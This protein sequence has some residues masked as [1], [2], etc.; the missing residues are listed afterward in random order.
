MWRLHFCPL[1]VNMRQ[2]AS[3]LCFSFFS[4]LVP[5][6]SVSDIVATQIVTKVRERCTDGAPKEVQE[7]IDGY[8][9]G[10]R[11]RGCFIVLVG[12]KLRGRDHSLVWGEGWS[13][14]VTLERW[15]EEVVVGW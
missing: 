7:R 5:T 14:R 6:V 12:S 3:R 8:R 11:K 4:G 1:T 13:E 9:R 2:W 10:P 15:I